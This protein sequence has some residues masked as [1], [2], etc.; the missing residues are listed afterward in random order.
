MRPITR[1]Y[2]SCADTVP[3]RSRVGEEVGND[4]VVDREPGLSA[5]IGAEDAGRRDADVH[6]LR[7]PRGELDRMAGHPARARE[8]PITRGVLE[9]AAIHLPALATVVRPEEHAGVTAEI[10]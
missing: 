3:P 6:A 4:V 2:A 5:V 9:D 10:K 7:V 1:S 8:P